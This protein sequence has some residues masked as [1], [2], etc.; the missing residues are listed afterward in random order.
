MSRNSSACG[1]GGIG[2]PT[3]VGG[4][5]LR[6]APRQDE[7]RWS[8]FVATRFYTRLPREACLLETGKAHSKIGRAETDKGQPGKSNARARWV[9]K[10]F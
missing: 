1:K 6:C 5:T 2:L 7:R 10:D 8:T 4:L 3:K 9:A